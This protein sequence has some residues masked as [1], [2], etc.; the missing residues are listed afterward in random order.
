MTLPIGLW[1]LA[2]VYGVKGARVQSLA[3]EIPAAVISL[4]VACPRIEIR[5]MG[6]AA[7][8]VP[9][10]APWRRAIG[11]RAV[12]GRRRWRRRRGHINGLW[13]KC[14]PDNSSNSEAKQSRAYCVA[15]PRVG[16][17]SQGDDRDCD[18]SRDSLHAYLV[19]CCFPLSKGI[20]VSSRYRAAL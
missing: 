12:I 17:R 18:G 4:K 16:G 10:R 5:A 19:H 2:G 1:G 14:A 15:V 20:T 3:A 13:R 11:C 9:A 6:V 7:I 8:A